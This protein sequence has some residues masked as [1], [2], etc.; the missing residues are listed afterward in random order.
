MKRINHILGVLLG[1]LLLVGLLGCDPAPGFL[2]EVEPNDDFD[3]ALSFWNRVGEGEISTSSDKDYWRLKVV[4]GNRYEIFLRNLED[5]LQ[6]M[7]YVFPSSISGW[8]IS[9]L[10]SIG[11]SD[12]EG[13]ISE[14]FSFTADDD[15]NI[16]FCV[17]G[18]GKYPEEETGYYRISYN[19]YY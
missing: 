19:E 8:N 7:M 3:T 5:N 18:S 13:T 15:Y 17:E 9:E 11:T 12:N 6:L 14:T 2:K 10:D 16:Q 1:C 4:A